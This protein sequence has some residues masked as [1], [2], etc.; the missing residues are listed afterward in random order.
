[1]QTASRRRKYSVHCATEQNCV[2]QQ[3][4]LSEKPTNSNFCC[5]LPCIEEPIHHLR[6]VSVVFAFYFRTIHTTNHVEHATH[7]KPA[8]D[9]K[10][11]NHFNITSSDRRTTFSHDIQHI[12]RH[13]AKPMAEQ[14]RRCIMHTRTRRRRRV[15][16]Y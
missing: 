15:R 5:I 3:N 10:R 14:N 13:S 16:K 12:P 8:H 4:C 6:Q 9:A 7:I 1:V 2:E 11:T